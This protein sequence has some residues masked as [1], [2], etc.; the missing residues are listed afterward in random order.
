M[1]AIELSSFADV[2]KARECARDLARAAGI[3]DSGAV[4]LATGELGN[5]CVEHGNH[6]P[7][8]LWI[9]CKPGHLSLRFENLCAQRPDWW[10]RKPLAVEEFRIGGYGLQLARV[11]AQCVNCRWAKGRVVVRAEFGQ[12]KA[13]RCSGIPGTRAAGGFRRSGVRASPCKAVRPSSEQLTPHTAT[14]V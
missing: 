2:R 9:G 3:Q 11:L 14:P 8:L 7:G 5:N 12:R 1:V 4:E 10:T 6:Q 13:F